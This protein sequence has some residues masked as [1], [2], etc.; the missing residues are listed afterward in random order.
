VRILRGFN[1][2]LTLGKFR[3]YIEEFKAGEPD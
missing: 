1:K 3:K 2:L